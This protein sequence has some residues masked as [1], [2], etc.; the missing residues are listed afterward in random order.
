MIGQYCLLKQ[1]HR[2]DPEKMILII[3]CSKDF[4]LQIRENRV[5]TSKIFSKPNLSAGMRTEL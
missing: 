1:Q 3:L 5:V 2:D 4:L